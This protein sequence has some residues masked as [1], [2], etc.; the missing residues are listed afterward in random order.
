[1]GDSAV[2]IRGLIKNFGKVQAL[3]GIDLEIETGQIY[4]FLGPNGAGKTTL[5]RSM[6]GATKA[7][8]GEISVLGIDPQK[9][10]I[11]LRKL[12]G[13]MP[14]TPALYEDLSPEDNIKFFGRANGAENINRK[15]N[16]V[17]EFVDLIDRRK[18]PV[19]N[20]SG[21]MKQRTSL[22]CALVNEP[23]ILF[24]DEPTSGI[25]PQLRDTFWKHFRVLA[26]RGITIFVSTHQMDEAMYCDRLAILHKGILLADDTPKNLLWKKEAR[27]RVWQNDKYE[28]LVFENYPEKLPNAL[29]KHGLDDSI[30]RIE[31]E[32]T[33]LETVILQ[34]IEEK[35]E[36]KEGGVK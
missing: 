7:S 10:K 24:L 1:M 13:Y 20:L 17:L 29:R 35:T 3:R 34:L 15:V 32:E 2:N 8:G 23:Q 19:H 33:S 16:E 4:G 9:N 25:D 18:D 31:V 21:G 27:I 5:I 30:T 12:I 6:I 11:E 36:G 22:A 14:Q 26:D 28:E